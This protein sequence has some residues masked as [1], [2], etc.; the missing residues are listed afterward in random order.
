MKVHF[1]IKLIENF[2]LNTLFPIKCLGCYEKDSILCDNCIASIRLVER[3]TEEKIQA[4]VEHISRVRTN[5]LKVGLKL[6]HG[7]EIEMGRMLIHHGHIHD[8]SKFTGIEFEHL[9][10]GD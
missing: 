3:Q 8:A 7:G 9:F 10:R 4:V 5:C 1:N 6:I 2:L